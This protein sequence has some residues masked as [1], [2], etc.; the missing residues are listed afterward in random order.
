M[1]EGESV[2]ITG[3][4]VESENHLGRS[5]IID[6]KSHGPSN[7]KQVDHRSIEYIIFKNVKYSLGK[8]TGDAPEQ[9]PVKHAHNVRKW[10]TSKLAIGNRFSSISYFKI[11][12]MVDKDTVLA[13]NIMEPSKIVKL[14]KDILVKEMHSSQIFETT[15]SVSRSNLVELM[16]N[17]KETVMTIEFRKKV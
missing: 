1:I 11:T 14:S 5:L 9:L 15:E 7:F 6:L 17:A 16:M 13:Y 4:L 8:R 10:D 12:Q 2:E 3:H